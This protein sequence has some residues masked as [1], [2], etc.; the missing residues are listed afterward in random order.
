MLEKVRRIGLTLTQ[1]ELERD[2]LREVTGEEGGAAGGWKMGTLG[3]DFFP[4]C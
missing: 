1:G 3:F 4:N 2:D